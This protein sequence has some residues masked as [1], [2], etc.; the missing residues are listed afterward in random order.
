MTKDVCQRSMLCRPLFLLP[1]R[2]PVLKGLH[3]VGSRQ[4][5]VSHQLVHLAVLHRPVAWC[6][7][8]TRRIVSPLIRAMEL[9]DEAAGMPISH[10]GRVME[11]ARGHGG[12][13]NPLPRDLHVRR[14]L[15]LL[16]QHRPL[17]KAVL[18]FSHRHL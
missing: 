18:V 1:T 5:P 8:R 4:L 7:S 17:V 3:P 12:I 11:M 16:G 9:Q 14:L 13:V 2:A 15:C 6:V 10:H